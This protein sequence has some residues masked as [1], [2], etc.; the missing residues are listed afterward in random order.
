MSHIFIEV[1]EFSVHLA[2][3]NRIERSG[4]DAYLTLLA[5]CCVSGHRVLFTNH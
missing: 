2:M 5:D 1:N 4:M 3:Y